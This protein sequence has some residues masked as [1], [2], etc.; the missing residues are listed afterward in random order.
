MK[1][2]GKDIHRSLEHGRHLPFFTPQEKGKGTG[3]EI[4]PEKQITVLEKN[5]KNDLQ[6]GYRSG[7]IVPQTGLQ[8]SHLSLCV[9]VCVCVSTHT[10]L[11]L[12]RGTWETLTRRFSQ[13]C[14]MLFYH[15]G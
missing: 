7:V 15:N 13:S 3:K 14:D 11:Y 9:C 1:L 6:S 10:A 5:L 2:T 4:P 12:V 8:V